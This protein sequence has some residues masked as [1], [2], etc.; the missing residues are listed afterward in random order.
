VLD[1]VRKDLRVE[2]VRALN[3][4]LAPLDIAPVYNFMCGFPGERPEDLRAT[5]RLM[6]SLLDGN[7]RARIP[8]AFVFVPYPGTELYEEAVRLGFSPPSSLEGWAGLD[9]ERVAV[10]WV[11][12]GARL[13][14]EGLS[15]A[16]MFLDGRSA[17]LSPSPAVSAMARLYRPLARARVERMRFGGLV[18]KRLAERFVL[19]EG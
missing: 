1:A 11:D 10:P 3:R 18:E 17:S 2:D 12:E 7:P 16:S 14:L 5:V 19:R 4:R 8:G 15:F 6:L 9:A 13:T